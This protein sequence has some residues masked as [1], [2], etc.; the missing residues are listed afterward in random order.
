M[1]FLFCECCSLQPCSLP[2]R[3]T[4]KTNIKQTTA[5]ATV[6]KK[7]IQTDSAKAMCD[8]LA[9]R[10]QGTCGWLRK[11]PSNH[12]IKLEACVH[13]QDD[14]TQTNLDGL[15]KCQT[16]SILATDTHMH[17]RPWDQWHV[18]LPRYPRGVPEPSEV[19][20]MPSS[21]RCRSVLPSS[22]HD[23][24][25]WSGTAAEPATRS[26]TWALHSINTTTYC[27]NVHDFQVHYEIKKQALI[28]ASVMSQSTYNR[29]FWSEWVEF[30][31]LFNT[32]QVILETSL[33]S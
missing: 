33:P 6:Q 17:Y 8:N 28:W 5:T 13:S 16:T 1:Q 21:Y 30:N 18:K 10:Q 3:V 15:N 12:L 27:Y 2:C 24:S 32:Q 20:A 25:M 7:P 31:I 22:V 14:H 9:V 29:S 26:S 11:P 19:R 23:E 4:A